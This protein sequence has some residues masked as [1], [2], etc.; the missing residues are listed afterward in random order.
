MLGSVSFESDLLSYHVTGM[1]KKFIML[2]CYIM[3]K[4]TCCYS[5]KS[6]DPFTMPCTF[7]A[8]YPHNAQNVQIL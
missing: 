8:Y 1:K 7:A 4:L 3:R 6:E 5:T 2:L